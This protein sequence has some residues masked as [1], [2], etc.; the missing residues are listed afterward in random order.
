[1][2]SFTLRRCPASHLSACLSSTSP[3]GATTKRALGQ[4]TGVTPAENHEMPRSSRPKDNSPSPYF[5]LPC[6]QISFSRYSNASTNQPAS[7]PSVFP[8][9]S[10]NSSNC[11]ISPPLQL[12]PYDVDITS[13]ILYLLVQH[14]TMVT[15]PPSGVRLVQQ[16]GKAAIV[17]Q[18]CKREWSLC[19][20]CHIIGLLFDPLP[21]TPTL[22][23]TPNSSE[24][25][26]WCF[27]VS[28][29]NNKRTFHWQLKCPV[30]R[31]LD[32]QPLVQ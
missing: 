20:W 12:R 25:V 7:N 18:G 28:V 32:D 8:G 14:V 24:K 9:I 30:I 4:M 26:G 1:M 16:K 13:V 21:P 6:W 11:Q 31:Y 29:Q 10:V 22:H 2:Q 15:L 23:T 3:P 5:S 27:C 19:S 17:C